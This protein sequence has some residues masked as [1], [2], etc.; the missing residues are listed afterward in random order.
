MLAHMYAGEALIMMDRMLEARPFLEPS[1]LATL[2]TFDFE[3]RDW[4][5]KSLDAA[6]SIMRYNLSV[7][8]TLQGD[9]DMA[10]SL[11]MNCSHPLLATKVF[12]LKVY[13]D[14]SQSNVLM[15]STNV[16]VGGIGIGSLTA[17]PPSSTVPGTTGGMMMMGQMMPPPHLPGRM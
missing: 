13:I 17:P 6:Q 10:R 3:T 15:A 1:F 4:Q 2:N 11:L 16:M 12:A 8:L 5:V 7:A 14:K 9:F